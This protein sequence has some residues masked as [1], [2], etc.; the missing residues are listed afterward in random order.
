[1][2]KDKKKAGGIHIPKMENKRAFFNYE[3]VEKVEA[4]MSLLGSEVKSLRQGG[5]DMAGSFA[6]IINNQCWLVGCNI[7]PYKQ[8]NIRNHEPLRSRKLLLHKKQITKIEGKMQQKGFTLVPLRIY[9][10]DRGIAKVELGIA[11]GKRKYDKRDK[12]T[13]RQQKSDIEKSTRKYRK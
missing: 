6:R 9:F 7:A 13:K 10:N 12:I 3:I 4:G 8:A 11:R 1:M 2:S 5:A